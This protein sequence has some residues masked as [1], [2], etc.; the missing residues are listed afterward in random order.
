M[1]DLSLPTFTPLLGSVAGTLSQL[2]L[3]YPL[4]ALCGPWPNLW[5]FVSE[6]GLSAEFR[7]I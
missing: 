5:T 6:I 4:W 2:G 7:D 3:R 1:H